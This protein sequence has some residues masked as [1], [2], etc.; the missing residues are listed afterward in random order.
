MAEGLCIDELCQL[1]VKIQAFL[2]VCNVPV[3]VIDAPGQI[4]DVVLGSPEVL[5]CRLCERVC[6]DVPQSGLDEGRGIEDAFVVK[7]E[8]EVRKICVLVELRYADPAALPEGSMV[9]GCQG[10]IVIAVDSVR[11]LAEKVV[12]A[13]DEASTRD[14]EIVHVSVF[15]LFCIREIVVGKEIP[16]LI[17]FK[18]SAEI[19][20]PVA[21]RER[22][23]LAYDRQL[24][25]PRRLE[26]FIRENEG[27]FPPE[28]I[29]AAFGDHVQRSRIQ[30]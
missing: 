14:K 22:V 24:V 9:Y 20:I 1:D 23:G 10:K 4:L 29:A 28:V 12:A 27:G 5:V 16:E 13:C 30:D 2:I 11:E 6:S 15:C 7:P 26:A 3:R 21:V 19:E 25:H 8:Y 17:L 18:R